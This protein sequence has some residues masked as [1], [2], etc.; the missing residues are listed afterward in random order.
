MN[1]TAKILYDAA[2][3]IDANGWCQGVNRS[4]EGY[5]CALGAIGKAS[6]FGEVLPPV[7]ALR[8][9]IRST[10]VAEWNDEPGRTK[11]QATTALRNAARTAEAVTA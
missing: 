8:R 6:M 7:E 2:D 3:L 9:E 1:T 10:G 11:D 4:A 5:Y